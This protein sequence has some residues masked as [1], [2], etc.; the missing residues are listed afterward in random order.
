MLT[1][2]PVVFFYGRIMLRAKNYFSV[3]KQQQDSPS[4]PRDHACRSPPKNLTPLRWR[5][6][7][8]FIA[9]ACRCPCKQSHFLF[10]LRFVRFFFLDPF[11]FWTLG[12]E[13]VLVGGERTPA[14]HA[15]GGGMHVRVSFRRHAIKRSRVVAVHELS[16]YLGHTSKSDQ[17]AQQTWAS[18]H[19]D[20]RV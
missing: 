3:A 14:R 6:L 5:V 11:C 8:Q 17:R 2:L 15:V 16:Q 18:S 13:A 19:G 12:G 7:C 10:L 1:S 9:L 20:V 4:S